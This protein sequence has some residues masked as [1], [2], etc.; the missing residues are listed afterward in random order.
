MRW[1][2]KKIELWLGKTDNKIERNNKKIEKNNRK[3]DQHDWREHLNENCFQRCKC[4]IFN[5]FNACDQRALET[6]TQQKNKINNI[7]QEKSRDEE[8]AENERN[9]NNCVNTQVKHDKYVA[10]TKEYHRNQKI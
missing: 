7:N 6:T 10:C 9:K 5:V 4:C 1:R 2:S 8:N 3:D